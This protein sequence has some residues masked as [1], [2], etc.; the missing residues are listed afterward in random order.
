MYRCKDRCRFFEG[1][2]SP[3]GRFMYQDGTIFCKL[4][5]CAYRFITNNCPCCGAQVRRSTWNGINRKARLGEYAPELVDKVM[6]SSESTDWITPKWLYD[7]LDEEFHFDLDPCTTKD[8]PLKT[9][10]FY[11]KR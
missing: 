2:R 3:V 9:K 6:F 4:C 5:Y 1:Y 11:T 7:K 10:N 8:N